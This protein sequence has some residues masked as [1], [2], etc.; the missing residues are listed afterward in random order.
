MAHTECTTTVWGLSGVSSGSSSPQKVV[1]KSRKS[2]KW[3]RQTLQCTI[4]NELGKLL[5]LDAKAQRKSFY[6]PMIG[7]HFWLLL[8]SCGSRRAIS[9]WS[10]LQKMR[11]P[12]NW[13]PLTFTFRW[14]RGLKKV[15][16]KLLL[17]GLAVP[18]AP[19]AALY[20]PFQL[21]IYSVT[22]E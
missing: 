20:L 4:N 14:Q 9:D 7:S 15:N 17:N 1:H 2:K 12:L 13:W 3:P 21:N 19:G 18:Y 8:P 6:F 22:L 10:L 11:W 16:H 5:L